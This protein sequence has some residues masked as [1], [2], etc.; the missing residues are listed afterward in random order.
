MYM[1]GVFF[2][3]FL[4]LICCPSLFAAQLSGELTTMLGTD[5]VSS[6]F[7]LDVEQKSRS[8]FDWS[9]GF[10]AAFRLCDSSPPQLATR[11]G[12]GARIARDGQVLIKHNLP[13]FTSADI[14]RLIDKNQYTAGSYFA[15]FQTAQLKLGLLKNVPL[16]TVDV[17][18]A[19]FLETVLDI[20]PMAITGLQVRYAGITE[21]GNTAVLQAQVKIGAAQALVAKGWH[22]DSKGEEHQGSVLEITG[23]GQ[24]LSGTFVAQCID[25][26]FVSVLAKTNRYT[27]NRQGWRLELAT[28]YKRLELSLN[29]RRLT[30]RNGGR[31]YNQLV[32]RLNAKDKHTSLEWRIQPTPAF[33]MRY[34]LADTLFQFDPANSTFRIDFG[35]ADGLFSVRFDAMRSILRLE[36]KQKQP[37][38]WR[39]ITKR[40]FALDR[41]HFSLLF[42]FSG[43]DHHLQIELGEYDRGNMSSGFNNSPSFCISWGWKF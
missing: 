35:V 25:P 41:S 10:D 27:P 39:I 38:E 3:L 4:L 11:W 19:V 13:H 42:R 17:V 2:T 28:E 8:W 12:W 30:S 36:Y 1:R 29:L 5:G 33:I 18:D 43:K 9:W 14:F 22:S 26:G 6:T 40:D 32:W 31:D 21:V 15:A 7:S 20:G 24:I 16:K 23:Q 34:N 37:L